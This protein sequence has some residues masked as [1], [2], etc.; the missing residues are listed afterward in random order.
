MVL[1]KAIKKMKEN[2]NMDLP[3]DKMQAIPPSP[4]GNVPDNALTRDLNAQPQS[5]QTFS[6]SPSIPT[7]N[8]FGVPPTERPSTP[9]EMAIFDKEINRRIRLA[10][11]NVTEA[12]AQLAKEASQSTEGQARQQQ[13]ILEERRK[14]LQSLTSTI[15]QAGSPSQK[16]NYTL[17]S[18]ILESA[19]E[20][21]TDIGTR[22][23]GGATAGAIFGA[24]GGT[25]TLPVFGTVVGAGGGA[26]V[27]GVGGAIASIPSIISNLKTQE[28]EKTEAVS[29]DFTTSKANIK[30]I[31]LYAKGGGDPIT[32]RDLYNQE[33]TKIYQSE[34]NLKQLSERDW[35]TKAKKDL[36]A[37]EAFRR[38]QITFD[39]AL[40]N[41]ILKNP[42][43]NY[44]F[45]NDIEVIPNE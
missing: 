12:F 25:A 4:F 38:N 11:G 1:L 10:N 2:P 33:L 39:T 28:R 36:T 16:L 43:A 18:S 13:A 45:L 35:L 40:E 32:A 22:T 8:A 9:E 14:A 30:A 37:I 29:L 15:G 21:L 26:I 5:I 42:D 3:D 7:Q 24:T 44:D 17:G 20:T 6:S 27:G 23:A 34:S 31:I 41:A 19:P